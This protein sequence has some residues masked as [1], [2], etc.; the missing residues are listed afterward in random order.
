VTASHED[1][2]RDLVERSGGVDSLSTFQIEIANTVAGLLSGELRAGDPDAASTV[3]KLLP[4]LPPAARDRP[5]P[6]RPL[7]THR[8]TLAEAARIYQQSLRE[9]GD[10]DDYDEREDPALSDADTEAIV[11]RLTQAKERGVTVTRGSVKLAVFAL[12]YEGPE[13]LEQLCEFVEGVEKE[14]APA[15][16]SPSRGASLRAARTA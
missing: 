11:G 10:P 7:I 9:S 14:P 2:F 13:A 1:I 15:E 8:T 6:L 12:K 16:R 5:R 4:H 3:A